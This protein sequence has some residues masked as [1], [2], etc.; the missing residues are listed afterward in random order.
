MK[1]VL[2]V[3]PVEDRHKE[4]L[5]RAAAGRCTLVY[6]A[7]S[8][9]S[10]EDLQ[11]VDALIGNLPVELV[12]QGEKLSWVQLNSAGADAYSVPG[13]LPEEAVLTN[14]SGAYTVAVSEHMLALTMD[15]IRH[16]GA[17]HTHQERHEWVSEGRITSVW[18]STVLILGIGDIGSAYARQVKGMGAAR[19]IGVRRRAD[20]PLPE[21]VD[22][23]YAMSDL[24][25]LLP[26]A[27]IVAMVLPGTR[28]T[29]H[30]MDERRL[31]L[32]RRGAVLINVGRGNAIDPEALKRVMREGVLGGVGLDVTEPEPLPA[33]DELWDLPG[34]TITPH[35]A[36]QFYLQ[37][38]FERIV[39]IAAGNLQAFLGDHDF[40]HVVNR[41]AGY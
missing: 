41:R 14:S 24:D 6:K 28:E 16:F 11:G 7:K 38:T 21:G 9:V 30:L 26:Q 33:E 10:A 31:R 4:M 5:E 37:E 20:R 36:G 27:D 18:G 34:V 1:K 15:L 13:I 29:V 35:V 8:E 32:M 12:R 39:R 17:Y 40:D 23:Q 25:R 2:V 19:V 22:E 3:I